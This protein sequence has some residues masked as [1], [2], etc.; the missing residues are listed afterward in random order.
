MAVLAAADVPLRARQVCEAMNMEI[1]PNNINT[2]L[3]PQRL[4]ERG[5]LVETEQGLFAPA[6][7]VAARRPLRPACLPQPTEQY[8]H[9]FAY[10][11]LRWGAKTSLG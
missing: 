9:Q 3:K 7:A 4:S 11:P 1:A 8:G 6:A 5:I 10:R 2:R